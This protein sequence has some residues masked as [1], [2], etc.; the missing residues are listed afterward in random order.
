MCPAWLAR[1]LMS[2]FSSFFSFLSSA[3]VL[4]TTVDAVRLR[5]NVDV[6]GN[7]DRDAT[8]AGNADFCATVVETVFT[9]VCPISASVNVSKM[10]LHPIFICWNSVEYRSST[11]KF[12]L[13]RSR[14]WNLLIRSQTRYP[15]R[16]KPRRS[17][18]D[19]Y[20]L[21]N[22]SDFAFTLSCNNNWTHL[23]DSLWCIWYNRHRLHPFSLPRAWI[24]H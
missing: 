18:N 11:K 15:L 10:S 20:K 4:L 7:D 6:A 3:T 22:S 21:L 9:S 13:A 16:H 5:A 19:Y 17:L 1:G 12:E 8:V 23:L 24:E 14:T 2:N